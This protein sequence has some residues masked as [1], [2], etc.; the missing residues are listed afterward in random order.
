[1]IY[2]L[3]FFSNTFYFKIIMD[4]YAVVRNN[5]AR[6]HVPFTQLS[7]MVTSCITIVQNY[8]QDMDIDTVKI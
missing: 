7:P 4:L 8:N 5:T 2:I 3:V 1:M 6:S